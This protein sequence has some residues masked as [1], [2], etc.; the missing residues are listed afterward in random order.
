MLRILEEVVVGAD[1]QQMAD[2]GHHQVQVQIDIHIAEVDVVVDVPSHCAAAAHRYRR[3]GAPE[4]C[5]S[6]G[7]R[8][9]VGVLRGVGVVLLL[10]YQK[11]LELALGIS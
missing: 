2:V 7:L 5:V 4:G 11:S 6:C 9:P 10:V 8:V 3:F 1:L